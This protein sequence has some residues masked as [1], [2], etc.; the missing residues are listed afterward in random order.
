MKPGVHQRS[1]GL[2]NVMR[3]LELSRW[4]EEHS[5][6]MRFLAQLNIASKFGYVDIDK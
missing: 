6:H 5:E 4:M 1:T 2:T 3:R